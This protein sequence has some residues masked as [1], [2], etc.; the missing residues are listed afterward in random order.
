MSGISAPMTVPVSQPLYSSPKI[1]CVTSH[2]A[3]CPHDLPPVERR[4]LYD[5]EPFRG[6][7]NQIQVFTWHAHQAN[8]PERQYGQKKRGNPFGRHIGAVR[9]KIAF[10]IISRAK[11]VK[12][13]WHTKRESGRPVQISGKPAVVTVSSRPTVFQGKRGSRCCPP[14][15]DES[16]AL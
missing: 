9:T 8:T 5:Q 1:G 4:A 14:L 7:D 6:N 15:R 3:V 12:A 11:T 10:A 2:E 16:Q 13:E